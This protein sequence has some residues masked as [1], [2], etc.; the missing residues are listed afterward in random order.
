[1]G[2]FQPQL[3]IENV[4]LPPE[5]EEAL[6]KRASIGVLGNMQQYAQY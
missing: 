6:D 2:Y 3:L 4:S 1:L 5:V